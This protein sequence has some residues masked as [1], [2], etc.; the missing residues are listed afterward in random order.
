MAMRRPYAF[1]NY[2]YKAWDRD[3][4]ES[5]DTRTFKSYKELKK[6]L[7]AMLKEDRENIVT[8]YRQRRGEWGEWFEKWGLLN[9]KPVLLKSGW[10]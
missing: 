7:V 6:N 3:R 2:V 8:V 4:V 10:L 1:L 9:G 5:H